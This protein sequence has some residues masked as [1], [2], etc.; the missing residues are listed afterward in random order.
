MVEKSKQPQVADK[1]HVESLQ[2]DTLLTRQVMAQALTAAGFPMSAATLATMATRGGGPPYRV[3]GGKKP[4]YLW[5]EALDW[6]HSRLSK[7]IHS[8]SELEVA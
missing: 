3:W 6:A 2:R 5:G 1:V 8:T 7:P 4:L